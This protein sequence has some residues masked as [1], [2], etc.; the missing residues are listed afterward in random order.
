MPHEAIGSALPLV[1]NQGC[2]VPATGLMQGLH[3]M[4][5]AMPCSIQPPVTHTTMKKKKE[6]KRKKKKNKKKNRKKNKKTT[7][8]LCA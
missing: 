5:P 1:R 8:N 6:K 3:C 2:H 4:Q 7:N